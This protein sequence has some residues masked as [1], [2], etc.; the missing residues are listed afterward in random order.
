MRSF[1]SLSAGHS[2]REGRSKSGFVI[3]RYRMPSANLRT[4]LMKTISRA[5]LE[6]WPKLFHNLR[7]TRET[8]LAAD[9]PLHVVCKWIGNSIQVATR[10]YLQV[11]D[12]DS[13]RAAGDVR[14]NPLQQVAELVANARQ[15]D[16]IGDEARLVKPKKQG[17]NL[18]LTGRKEYPRQ[19]SNLWPP[20]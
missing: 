11:R 17:K 13:E 6:P 18:P 5:G 9:F 20:I 3:T 12:E 14:Q 8:E 7:A 15:G 10:N 2:P 19:E 1:G 4:R 16:E